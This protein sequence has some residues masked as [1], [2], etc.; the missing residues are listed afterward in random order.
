MKDL[1]VPI[2][3]NDGIDWSGWSGN[4]CQVNWSVRS[5]Q[6][7]SH[8]SRIQQGSRLESIHGH[9]VMFAQLVHVE[10]LRAPRQHQE[11]A[12]VGQRQ[13]SADSIDTDEDTGEQVF[14]AAGTCDV[15]RP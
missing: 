13:R 10:S 6:R 4:V 1:N 8:R 3:I 15:R 9:S 12:L 5:G 14:N 2:G 11:W 7:R